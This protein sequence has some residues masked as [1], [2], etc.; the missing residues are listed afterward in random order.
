[1]NLNNNFEIYTNH[2]SLL[3]SI[4]EKCEFNRIKLMIFYFTNTISNLEDTYLTENSLNNFKK[5][6][7][8]LITPIINNIVQRNPVTIPLKSYENEVMKILREFYGNN[9]IKNYSKIYANKS[10]LEEKGKK[11]YD[12]LSQSF[13]EF[14]TIFYDKYFYSEF[15]N[16]VEK[17]NEIL[18]KFNQIADF[19]K[20]YFNNPAEKL[21]EII[22]NS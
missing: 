8:N 17:P 19:Q 9:L 2:L 5:Q 21:N 12:D 11:F 16:Y 6:L 10:F 7:D 22:Y 3:D 1:M 15:K 4:H 18:T 14:K 20:N 13:N